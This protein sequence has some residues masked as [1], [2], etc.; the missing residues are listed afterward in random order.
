MQQNRFAH[1]MAP[2]LFRPATNQEWMTSTAAIVLE[3]LAKMPR[4]ETREAMCGQCFVLGLRW[5]RAL[6]FLRLETMTSFWCIHRPPFWS[7]SPGRELGR[8]ENVLGPEIRDLYKMRCFHDGFCSGFDRQSSW[9]PM[10]SNV[11][12][13]PSSIMSCQCHADTCSYVLQAAQRFEGCALS[14]WS[15]WNFAWLESG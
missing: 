7:V 13:C 11:L 10:S 15:Q 1:T 8:I 4:I 6:V 14:C 9:R 5:H 2:V 3:T 12:P